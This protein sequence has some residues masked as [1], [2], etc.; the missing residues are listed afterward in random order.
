[1]NKTIEIQLSEEI[2]YMKEETNNLKEKVS[3]LEDTVKKCYGELHTKEKVLEYV[4]KEYNER[5][6]KIEKDFDKQK[7][8]LFTKKKK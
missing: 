2:Y 7:E 4:R 5:V 6:K 8:E 3:Q 1:M